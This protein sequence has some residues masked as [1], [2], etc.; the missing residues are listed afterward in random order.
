M[1]SYKM[2]VKLEPSED[3]QLQFVVV[4]YDLLA[5]FP[6]NPPAEQ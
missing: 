4:I 2:G 3:N 6:L 5:V 1:R